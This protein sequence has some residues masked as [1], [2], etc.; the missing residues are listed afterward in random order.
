MPSSHPT[1]PARGIAAKK[2]ARREAVLNEAALQMNS[3]GAGA[4]NLN[5]IA[6]KVGLSR[7]A[8]YH[9]VTDRADVAFRCYLR[10]CETMTED[11][12]IAIESSTLPDQWIVGFIER[13][14]ATERAPLAILSDLDFLPEPQRAIIATLNRA[15]VDRL[16][17]MMNDGIMAGAF[18]SMDVEISA[19]SLLG[20]LNWVQLSPNWLDHSNGLAARRR[21]ASSISD[22]FL[23]G[24]ARDRSRQFDCSIRTDQLTARQFN[25]FDRAQAT[26]QKIAQLIAAA[27]RLFN[28]RG[29]DGASLDDISA[30]VGATKGAVYHYFED[31][32]D[33]VVQCYERAFDFYDLCMETGNSQ[34]GDGL[35][36]ALT[37]FHLNCQAQ[38]SAAPPL[39]LQPGLKALPRPHRL[40]LIQRAKRLWASA[41]DICAEGIEDGSYRD[42]DQQTIAEFPAG[43]FFWISKWLAEEHDTNPEQIANAMSQLMVQGIRN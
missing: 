2:A 35:Q 4:V 26:E 3:R 27:S 12:A 13:T 40:R 31:R 18:R 5:A 10:S 38:A 42:L 23:N 22:V 36:R 33:L 9:Y 43:A 28:R 7:N 37:G 39:I 16:A 11:L 20:I 41:Q 30:S 14:L 8:L 29:I 34:T 17:G 19:Q 24:V 6:T 32:T 25:T 15:N 1:T 21:S